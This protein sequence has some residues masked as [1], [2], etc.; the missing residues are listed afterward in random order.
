L[1]VFEIPPTRLTAQI[2]R[3]AGQFLATQA[4]NCEWAASLLGEFFSFATSSHSAMTE[5][6]LS[7]NSELRETVVK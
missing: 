2:L 7:A 5:G 3:K 1:R 4:A 6:E